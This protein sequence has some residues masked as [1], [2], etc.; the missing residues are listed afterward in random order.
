MWQ[1]NV[2]ILQHRSGQP[3]YLKYLKLKVY[4]VSQKDAPILIL[5]V[6]NVSNLAI[7]CLISLICDLPEL[8]DGF[9]TSWWLNVFFKILF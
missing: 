4:G 8:A 1:V 7:N 2:L 3:I 5:L 9:I 6:K